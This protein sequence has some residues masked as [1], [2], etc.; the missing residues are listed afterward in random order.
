ME[1]NPKSERD[2]RRYKAYA[3]YRDEMGVSDYYISKQ[4]GV[5]ASTFSEWGKG[6]YCPS[7]DTLL[8]ICEVIKVPLEKILVD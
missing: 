8:R 1:R 7:A 3:Q 5:S 4:S 6:L 2:M